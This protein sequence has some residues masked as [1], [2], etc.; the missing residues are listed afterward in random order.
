MVRVIFNAQY[1]T[2]IT[3]IINN[4]V[5]IREKQGGNK[6]DFQNIFKI[7]EEQLTILTRLEYNSVLAYLFKVSYAIR[8]CGQMIFPYD[9]Y[10]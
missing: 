8:R 7:M 2:T 3:P 5:K 1:S 10:P 6:P 4:I 9:L